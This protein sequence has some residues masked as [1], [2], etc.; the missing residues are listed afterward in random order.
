MPLDGGEETMV[1]DLVQQKPFGVTEDG[2]R[3]VHSGAI[4]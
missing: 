4:S 1:I 2:K 3:I